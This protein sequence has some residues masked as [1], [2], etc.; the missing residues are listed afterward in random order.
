MLASFDYEYST[1][2][3]PYHSLLI[4]LDMKILR[5]NTSHCSSWREQGGEKSYPVSQNCLYPSKWLQKAL[6]QHQSKVSSDTV[7][8]FKSVFEAVKTHPRKVQV[9]CAR[10][11]FFGGVYTGKKMVSHTWREAALNNL[12]P[13][14]LLCGSLLITE[15]FTHVCHKDGNLWQLGKSYYFRDEEYFFF[16]RELQPL[17]IHWPY[18]YSLK[19]SGKLIPL[20]TTHHLNNHL[21]SGKLSCYFPFYSE[22]VPCCTP[23]STPLE[24][25][26]LTTEA[27]AMLKNDWEDKVGMKVF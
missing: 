18:K 19:E 20:G 8:R 13:K 10:N 16:V 5:E 7:K 12:F 24:A 14:Q 4:I 6:E 26:R 11:T 25:R 17:V 23:W 21:I 15:Y 22:Q 3:S 9:T 2:P 1:E 27:S